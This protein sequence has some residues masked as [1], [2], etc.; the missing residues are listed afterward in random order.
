MH[1]DDT[2]DEHYSEF[3]DSHRLAGLVRKYSDYI[4]YPIRM[5]MEKRRKKEGSDNEFETYREI[6]TLNSMVPLWKKKKSEVTAE[7][8]NGFYKDK[9]FDFTDPLRVIH[10][11]AEGTVSYNAL[12]FIPERPPFDFFSKEFQKDLR[13]YSGG[14]LIMEK[15]QDLLPS[16]FSFVRGIVDTPDVSLN[17]SREMLQHDRQLK[18]IAKSLEKRVKNELVKMLEDDREKYETFWKSFRLP[19]K[20]GVY[21]GYG[22]NKELLQDLLLFTSLK[23]GK[24]VTLNEYVAA[25]PEGQDYIYYACGESAEKIGRQPQI[26]RVSDKGYD[27]LCLSDDVDEFALKMLGAYK[28]KSFKSVAD[29]D[30]GLDSEEEKQEAD[31]KSEAS[32]DLLAALKESLKGKVSDVKLSKRLKTHPV[33]L[34]AEGGISLEMEKVFA[35]MPMEEKLKAK[36]VLELN[37]DHPVFE[38]LCRL[39]GTDR[40]K[41]ATYAELL[42]GQALMIEGLPV[43]DPVAFSEAV[44]ELMKD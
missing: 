16:Y 12:L 21:E 44:C 43:D 33:C 34:T 15:C 19:I 23:T 18:V 37:P 39:Y 20:Y 9:F 6:E 30:L 25:M 11:S 7:E 32:K 14:V 31:Q 4:R 17:I 42:Y 28:E 38:T 27:I 8:Y 40:D 22:A 13:L 5:E 29:E 36:R 26:E 1:K 24:Y 41:L 3:L 35:A 10:Y 2:E